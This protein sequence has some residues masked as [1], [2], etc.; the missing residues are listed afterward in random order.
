[1]RCRSCQDAAVV[2][3]RRHHGAFCARWFVRHCREAA[4]YFGFLE[5]VSHHFVPEA[6]AEQ[7]QLGRC[8]SCGAATTGEVCA[9]CKLRARAGSTSP[10]AV[11]HS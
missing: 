1:M 2:E 6:R 9:F 7:E 8:S 4:F 3:V 5:R 11:S 10:G